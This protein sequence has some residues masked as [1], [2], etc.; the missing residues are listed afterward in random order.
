MYPIS[1]NHIQKSME[2]QVG[3]IS[4]TERREDIDNDYRPL[5]FHLTGTD[6]ISL[7][8]DIWESF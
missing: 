2:N 1:R 3:T 5:R 6:K 4:L 7:G 8:L